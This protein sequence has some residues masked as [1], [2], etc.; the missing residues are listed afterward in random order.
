MAKPR[1]L[2]EIPDEELMLELQAG[3][4]E[5]FNEIVNRYKDYSVRF[6]YRFVRDLELSEDGYKILL[7]QN[8]DE[9]TSI[10]KEGCSDL[11]IID[12][13][14]LLSK[15]ISPLERIRNFCKRTLIV[16][17]DIS[18]DTCE[19]LLDSLLID[20]CLVKS[21]DLDQL[22]WKIKEVLKK[23]SYPEGIHKRE[24]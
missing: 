18:Y 14:L 21:S 13:E 12:G 22:R 7:A 20:S 19:N 16:L 2:N 3:R 4:E 5:A 9:A 15:G 6:C 10:L 17:N 23:N 8:E 1:S 24:F 11:V